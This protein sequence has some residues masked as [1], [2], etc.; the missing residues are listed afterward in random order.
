[1]SASISERVH[2]AKARFVMKTAEYPTD[3]FLGPKEY[4][5]LKELIRGN[6]MYERIDAIAS[7]EEFA[8]MRVIGL[9]TDG[10]RAGISVSDND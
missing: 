8:G 9:M 7:H 10:C 2:N 1:M 6:P 4:H 3:I 5:E